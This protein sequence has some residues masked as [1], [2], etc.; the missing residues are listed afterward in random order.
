MIVRLEERGVVMDW[1]ATGE[2]GGRH[3]VSVATTAAVASHPRIWGFKSNDTL[4]HVDII[5]SL[6]KFSAQN[7][8][9]EDFWRR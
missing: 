9:D 5:L 6:F 7:A 3:G 1:D 2:L 8:I 4:K